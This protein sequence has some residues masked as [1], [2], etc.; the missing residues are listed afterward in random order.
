[1]TPEEIQSVA[2]YHM[3]YT[4]LLLEL[5][6]AK[7][8]LTEEMVKACQNHAHLLCQRVKEIPHG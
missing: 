3:I 1:M 7:M 6:G 8:G 5:V 4:T 2:L